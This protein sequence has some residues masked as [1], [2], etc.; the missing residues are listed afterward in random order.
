MASFVDLSLESR[1]TLDARQSCP[2]TCTM[3]VVGGVL[4]LCSDSS[5]DTLKNYFPAS[6]ALLRLATSKKQCYWASANKLQRVPCMERRLYLVGRASKKSS[7][8]RS[9]LLTV[10]GP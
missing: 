3:R 5:S 9:S 1:A 8:A 2:S 7:S 6:A 10:V 4:E